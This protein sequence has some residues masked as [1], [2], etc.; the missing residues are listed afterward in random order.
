MLESQIRPGTRGLPGSL[1]SL[2]VAITATRGAARASTEPCPLA[3]SSASWAGPSLVPSGSSSVPAA[4]SSP[5]SR[6]EWPLGTGRE[7]RA[8]RLPPSVHSTG[9][10]AS[11]PPGIMAPV[12]IRMH[13]PGATVTARM[14]PAGI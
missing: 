4:T 5:I 8:C 14:S 3:A 10:T 2:P 13:V 6:I 1:S 12:M 7:N 11:A 9:T